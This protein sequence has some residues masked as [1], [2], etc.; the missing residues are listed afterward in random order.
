MRLINSTYHQK[1]Q[2]KTDSEL[3][4]LYKETNNTNY[5]GELFNRYHHLVFGVAL[6]Y[7]HHPDLAEDALLELFSRLFEQLQKYQIDDFKHWL[8][9][10]TRNYCLKY[11]KASS[12]TVAFENTHENIYS[13]DFM[14]SE[15]QLDLLFENEKRIELLQLALAQ[16]K[17]EQQQCV[18]M[19]YIDDRSYQYISDQTGFEVKKVKSYIQNGKRNLQLIMEQ[20]KK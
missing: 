8:L 16:L 15:H 5:V 12:Q 2:D 4:A 11:I 9:T 6:K 14:E 1:T 19:F 18:R 20:Y 13:V 7:L 17:P 10:V 3:I